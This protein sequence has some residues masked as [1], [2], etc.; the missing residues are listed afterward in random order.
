MM[1]NVGKRRVSMID[2]FFFSFDTILIY[3][4]EFDILLREYITIDC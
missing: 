2:E 3:K 1:G 4:I